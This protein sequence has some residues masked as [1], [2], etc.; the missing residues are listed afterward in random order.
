MSDVDSQDSNCEDHQNNEYPEG[1]ESSGY[2]DSKD[3][4]DDNRCFGGDDDDYYNEYGKMRK[5]KNESSSDEG[6]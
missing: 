2:G 1:D 4:D 5:N 6:Q 3:S